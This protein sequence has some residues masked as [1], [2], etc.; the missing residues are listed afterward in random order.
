MNSRESGKLADVCKD[1]CQVQGVVFWRRLVVSKPLKLV[2]N[3]RSSTRVQSEAVTRIMRVASVHSRGGWRREMV[4][5]WSPP[6]GEPCRLSSSTSL[7]SCTHPPLRICRL[8]FYK[9]TSSSSSCHYR[10]L[11][12][13][14]RNGHIL[15]NSKSASASGSWSTEGKEGKARNEEIENQLKRGQDDAVKRN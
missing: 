2:A 3:V 8:A 13:P 1:H 12:N 9:T 4:V 10:P 6:L 5:L 15:I 11:H 14:S 7:A